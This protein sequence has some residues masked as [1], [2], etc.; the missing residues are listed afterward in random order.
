MPRIVFPIFGSLMPLSLIW[1]SI[2]ALVLMGLVVDP[3]FSWFVPLLVPSTIW[4]LT[5]HTWSNTQLVRREKPR[6][7]AARTHD[8]KLIINYRKVAR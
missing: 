4:V 7:A 3:D 5:R 6:L 1:Y 8:Q 2:G